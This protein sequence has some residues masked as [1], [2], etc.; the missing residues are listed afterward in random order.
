[1]WY[2]QLKLNDGL[3]PWPRF[4]QLVNKRFGP[5]LTKSPIGEL[6]LLRHEGSVDE[7]AKKFMALSCCVTTI[8]EAHQVQLFLAGL[9]KLLSMDVALQCPSTLDNTVM[10][11]RA[12][13]QRSTVAAP[14]G[15]LS[16][17]PHS[18]CLPQRRHCP[19]LQQVPRRQKPV[20]SV[21]RLMPVEIAQRR[22]DRQCFHFDEFFTN[23]HQQV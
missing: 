6:A 20:S 3:P 5:L 10:L 18:R 21:K 4:V 1:L 12:Y 22:K 15:E 11:A 19:N 2:H 9:S 8:T 16:H 14:P 13:D 7:F 23:G 17:A